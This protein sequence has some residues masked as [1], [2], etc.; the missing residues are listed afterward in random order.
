[1]YILKSKIF[2]NKALLAEKVGPGNLF[3][4]KLPLHLIVCIS[5][6]DGKSNKLGAYAI[7]FELSGSNNSRSFGL[8]IT[9]LLYCK[10]TFSNDVKVIKSL[11]NRM[12][13]KFW[14]ALNLNPI[15]SPDFLIEFFIEWHMC[16]LQ[17][18]V[19]AD[20]FIESLLSI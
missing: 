10:Y 17:T 13:Q 15:L 20:V 11:T 4:D 14:N 5:K 12:L 8:S 1:M 16:K 6:Q 9:T 18:R 2:L 7:L 3:G 19:S